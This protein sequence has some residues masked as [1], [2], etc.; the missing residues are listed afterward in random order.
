MKKNRQEVKVWMDKYEKDFAKEFPHFRSAMK[1]VRPRAEAAL[2][3][4]MELHQINE[5]E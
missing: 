3:V 1:Q 5:K 2:L 4:N